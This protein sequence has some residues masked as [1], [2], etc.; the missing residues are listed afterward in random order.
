VPEA[1]HDRLVL[2]LTTS[3]DGDRSPGLGQGTWRTDPPVATATRPL[4]S[5]SFAIDYGPFSPWWR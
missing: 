5:N 4:R 3:K 2:L 1:H